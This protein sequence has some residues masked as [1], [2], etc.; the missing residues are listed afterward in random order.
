[1]N[2]IQSKDIRNVSLISHGGA[3]K[4]TL[5][6]MFLYNSGQIKNP[7]SIENKN[8]HS[9][10]TA[11]EKKHQYSIINSY[12]S[13]PWKDKKINL[14]DTPGYADFK[15]EVA[16][17]LR[18]VETSILLID[19]ASGVQVNTEN[20]WSVAINNK[21]S[22]FVFINK[23][24][25]E[26][27]KFIEVYKEIKNKFDSTFVPVTIPYGE[28]SNYK[29]II[30]LL[31]KK[32][33]VLNNGVENEEEIPSEMQDLLND[34]HT[35]LVEEVV[36]LDDELMMKYLDEEEIN[37][38]ELINAL[39]KGVNKGSIVPVFAGSAKENSGIN[40]LFEYLLKLAPAP[41]INKVIKG[42]NEKEIE[43]KDDGPYAAIIGKTM[44]DP[45]IGKLS[46]F[47]VFTGKLTTDKDIYCSRLKSKFKN[48]KLYVL[49]GSEQEIVNELI[50]GDI[51]AIAK[52]DEL[53]TSDTICE[54]ELDIE[55][56]KIVFPQ[57]M[58]TKAALPASEGDDEKMSTALNRYSMEDPTFKVEYNAETK[59]LLITGMGTIHL[60]IIKD[61][62]KRKFD[63]DFVTSI[64]K[65]AYKETIQTK[66]EVE[67]KYKKQ[68]GGRG[69]Y[70]HVFI[71]MEPLERGKGF[72]FEE[73]IFG[74]AIPN[75]YIPAVEKGITEAKT[76][77][78]V[79][80]YP[81]VDFKAT[82]YDGSY[83]NVDSSEMA[84]KIA[85]SKAFKKGME[86]A[87]PVILEPIM[88]IEVSVPDEYMGDIM[89]DLNSRRGK[90]L[91]M[92][93]GEGR[94]IIKAQVPLA[95][96]FTY[97]TDLKS[98]TGGRGLYSMSFAHYDKVPKKVEEEIIAS[99]NKDE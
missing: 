7:G 81:V 61:V 4:T 21:L 3:G 18:M 47:R 57:P 39:I 69:Q 70:G 60:D 98:I 13:I 73:E 77:G 64:P 28:G 9:D 91:G 86:K 16:S 97:S 62:C 93:P 32:A 43:I 38:E 58:L 25:K 46:I 20:V 87:K 94:Q 14:I 53:E 34:M 79:A 84:F 67:E 75:Q 5:T 45:Y 51:G 22:K 29:G 52:I 24:D 78:I 80:G 65:V 55:L 50:A 1:L 30:D 37:D 40:A 54:P 56:E 72:I 89:G 76:E 88:E 23:M 92:N 48:S 68:S 82:V 17:A 12:F 83:H 95:E 19:G 36:E 2:V 26:E 96:L 90:I 44:V 63:V 41:D 33:F 8:T 6:E 66:V 71:R 99:R 85:S 59:E 49:N 11:E 35:E 31:R 15:G 27:V 10:F 74:G 42:K